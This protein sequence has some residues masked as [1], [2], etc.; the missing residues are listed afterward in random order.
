MNEI[1]QPESI[2]RLLTHAFA[3]NQ[4]KPYV[5]ELITLGRDAGLRD[6]LRDHIN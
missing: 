6:A 2:V 4:F 3:S 1:D 5:R